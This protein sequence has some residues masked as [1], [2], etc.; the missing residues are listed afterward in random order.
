MIV[1]FCEI[2]FMLWQCIMQS[3]LKQTDLSVYRSGHSGLMGYGDL[4]HRINFIIIIHC[5][6]LWGFMESPQLIYGKV[7]DDH[8]INP[9]KSEHGFSIINRAI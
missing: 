7:A 5:L 4:F 9:H 3:K 8:D 1:A 2:F 6:D